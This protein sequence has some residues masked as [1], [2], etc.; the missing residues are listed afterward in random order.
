MTEEHDEP[1]PGEDGR[2]GARFRRRGG[3]GTESPLRGRLPALVSAG[4]LLLAI[5]TG[6]GYLAARSGNDAGAA[7]E[8]TA[9]AAPRTA[10]GAGGEGSPIRTTGAPSQEPDSTRP[11][12]ARMTAAVTA[13]R[14]VIPSVV[15]VTVLRRERRVPRSLF[16][17]PFPF[18]YERTVEG[19]GSGFA[20]DDR[21]HVLTNEHVVRGA[22]RV[23]VTDRRGRTHEAEILGADE[24]TDIALLKIPADVVPAADVGTSSDLMVGEPAIA[25][26]NPYG[27]LFATVEATVTA[28]V[29][30]ALGR[31][32]RSG[33][34]RNA[35]YANMI[36]TDASVNPGNSGGPLVNALGEVIGVNASIVS[37]DGG[38]G[39]SVGIGFAIPIERALRVA[40][41]LRKHGRIR[42]PWVG[43]DLET[44]ADSLGRSRTVVRRVAPGSPAE[45]AGLRPG[46]VVRSLDGDPI[47]SP[48]D[49]RVKLLEAGVGTRVEVRY[50]RDGETRTA[51]LSVQEVPSERA[52]RVEVL[53]G[54][55]LITVTPEVAAERELQVERGALVVSVEERVAYLTGMRAGDV[56]LSVNRRP[57]EG[58]EDAA[59]LLRAQRGGH[60]LV[61]LY[62]QGATVTTTFRL[63]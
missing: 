12:P 17:F 28:G 63:R 11:D 53:E 32:I 52:E 59:R 58:A 21:G 38:S 25:V 55:E 35:L 16:D 13:A 2:R 40:D 30:S 57:V 54:I 46:D 45:E 61:R 19:L 6:V 49:W 44:M 62:R 29:V 42:R 37:P 50:S 33:R 15:S 4:A 3:G 60:V 18:G 56:L 20:M 36:Q 23:V 1:G 43:T 7:A 5:G 41:E 8:D 31:D 39:G 9:A 48:L 47:R 51:T 14:R 22:I 26:G 27:F 24:L 10:E 34:D